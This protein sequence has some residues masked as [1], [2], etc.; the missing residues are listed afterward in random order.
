MTSPAGWTTERHRTAIG[1]SGLSMPLRQALIDEILVPGNTVLDY[2]CGRGQDVRRLT[3]M[4]IEAQGWDPFYAPDSPLR[5]HEVVMLTYVLNVIEDPTERLHALNA[6]WQ[7]ARK[8]IVVSCRLDWEQRQVRGQST[9]D[10]LIT[11]R[12][13]FQHFYSTRELRA[14]VEKVTGGHCVSPV[15]GVVYAFRR[16]EDRLAY[17]ALNTI[18][19]FEWA[20]STDY[21]SALAE[22]IEFTEARGRVPMFEEI[23]PDVAPLLARVSRPNLVRLIQKGADS[24]RVKEGARKTTL[25]TLLYLGTSIFNGRARLADLPIPVQADIKYCFNSYR[26]ACARADRLLLKIRDDTYIR[27]AMRNSVGKLTATALYV[28]ERA[29]RSMPVVLRLYEHCGFVATGRPAGWNILKLDHRGRRVSWSSYPGFDS[30]PHP[31]LDWTFG[32]DMTT[33]DTHYQ[34]FVERSNRPLLHRKEEFLDFDDKMASKYRRLTA[35]EVRAGLY[36]DPTRIGLE[37]GWKA[38][39]EHC[40]VALKGHRLV[41]SP[42]SAQL[43]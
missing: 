2:G 11:S 43:N 7:L 31:T 24:D 35:A 17:L 16:E 32:V 39:L 40:G 19:E 3:H 29:T 20:T 27:G 34:S 12:D 9:G 21:V 36:R 10:G 6:A 37:T 26:E 1:R 33:L 41:K 23:P 14:L 25:D 42:S 13:T 38:A 4:G 30:D 5:E 28:H 18:S 8:A 22:V 15:P